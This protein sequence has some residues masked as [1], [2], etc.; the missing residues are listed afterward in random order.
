MLIS[1]EGARK[2]VL[3]LLSLLCFSAL[4]AVSAHEHP[5]V[6][7][8]TSMDVFS[9]GQ[10]THLLYS[11]ATTGGAP[12]VFYQRSDD[13]K[14]YSSPVRID[15]GLE[16]PTPAH[17]GMDLQIA[18]S[19]KHIVAVWEAKGTDRW[20][21]GPMVS[22]ISDDNGASWK[23]GPNPAN[24]GSTEGHN[25]MDMTANGSS[26]HIVWLD[27]RSGKK[28]LRYARSADGGTS[29]EANQT[30]DPNTC[31]CCWNTIVSAPQSKVGVLYRKK[32]PRDMAFLSSTDNGKHWSEPTYVGKF[33]WTIDGCPHVGGGLSIDDAKNP[34][35]YATV[36]TAKTA[37]SEGVY[38][39]SSADGG[40]TWTDPKLLGGKNSWHNDLVCGSK[41][42]IAA[43][44]D[45]REK[46]AIFASTSTDSG[47]SW[48][49]PKLLSAKGVTASHPRVLF[50]NDVFQVFWTEA[51]A[52]SP[53]VKVA[54]CTL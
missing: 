19:G 22:K 16:P 14:S 54:K 25:F 26:F 31:E 15:E 36:W 1:K 44:W 29:W 32:D 49:E 23:N 12:G 42:R 38:I 18:A 41:N 9:D 37:E 21:G 10:S 51:S 53:E 40:K 3:F 8:V 46:H 27:V 48:T 28:G 52:L 30:L 4:M 20:G 35:Y 17:R 33:N 50:N 6:T 39:L 11:K 2:S 7:G 5:A 34:K 13:G 45:D 47:K 43:V 24:D